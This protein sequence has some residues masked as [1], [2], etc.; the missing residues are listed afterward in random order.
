MTMSYVL[1][2]ITGIHQPRLVHM[3]T[4]Q[5]FSVYPLSGPLVHYT[6]SNKHTRWEKGTKKFQT[7]YTNAVIVQLKKPV[8]IRIIVHLLELE[9]DTEGE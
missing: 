7:L 1:Q 9:N 6:W 2:D 8:K 5:I 4:L 3:I